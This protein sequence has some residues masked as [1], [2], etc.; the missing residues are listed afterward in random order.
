MPTATAAAATGPASVT[1]SF[2]QVKGELERVCHRDIDGS[3]M[4]MKQAMGELLDCK[5]E[6]VE[7]EWKLVRDAVP[8]AGEQ[9]QLWST[10]VTDICR[11][12]ED[13]GWMH[14]DEGVR[15]YGTMYGYAYM[16][17]VDAM[18]GERMFVLRAA[19]TAG[20]EAVRLRAQQREPSATQA[21]RELSE[22]SQRLDAAKPAAVGSAGRGMDPI[23]EAELAE[24]RTS[25]KRGAELAQSIAQDVC[26]WQALLAGY[27]DL[28]ACQQSQRGYLLSYFDSSPYDK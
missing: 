16:D 15:D 13:S 23:T 17:C 11:L 14:L 5:R 28:T 3:N 2:E 8:W 12:S 26:R 24:A 4:A 18:L 10:M 20:A 1:A 6:R 7:A 21:E 9:Q 27:S 25:A 19:A 22:V